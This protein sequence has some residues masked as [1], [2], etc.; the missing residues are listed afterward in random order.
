MGREVTGSERARPATRDFF[1]DLS[2]Y[3]RAEGIAVPLQA[4]TDVVERGAWPQAQGGAVRALQLLS[5]RPE[6]AAYLVD[7]ARRE[8]GP[9]GYPELPLVLIESAW[10]GH[11][12]PGADEIRRTLS[13]RPDLIRNA[14]VRCM[15]ENPAAFDRELPPGLQVRCPR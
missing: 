3:V 12:M 15:V 5:D 14:T 1:L 7:L 6:V 4:L 10:N 9:A 8:Q 11:I 13:A 2:S